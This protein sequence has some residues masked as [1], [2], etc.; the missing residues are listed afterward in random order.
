MSIFGKKKGWNC[1]QVNEDGSR[2]CRR[3]EVHKDQRLAT[4]T[5]VTVGVDNDTCEPVFSGNPQTF[6]D[7][8]DEAISRV[9]KK[10]TS[11][12]KKDKGLS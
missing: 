1:D 10:M 11:K 6:L 3:F 8:D 12:C 4:G 2:T 5:E 9:A 7:D